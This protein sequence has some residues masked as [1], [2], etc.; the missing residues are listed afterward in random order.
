MT[1]ETLNSQVDLLREG[2]RER[3]RERENESA[4]IRGD[5]EVKGTRKSSSFAI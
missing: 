2:G 4:G 1:K 5:D 3:E